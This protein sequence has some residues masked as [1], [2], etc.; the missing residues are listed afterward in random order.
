MDARRI[1]WNRP[2]V[3]AIRAAASNQ[4]GG[5]A[6]VSTDRRL[7]CVVIVSFGASQFCFESNRTGEYANIVRPFFYREI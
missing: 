6:V 3:V 4:S 7:L 2:R 5:A 1:S